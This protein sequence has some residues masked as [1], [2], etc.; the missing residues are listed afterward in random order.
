MTATSSRRLA[1]ESTPAATAGRNTTVRARALVLAAA[2]VTGSGGLAFGLSVTQPPPMMDMAPESPVIQFGIPVVRLIDNT[3]GVAAGGLALLLLFLPRSRW[4]EEAV[5]ART[6]A[7]QA[8]V[9]VGLVWAAAALGALWSQAAE[10]SPNGLG[11]S[12]G[13]VIGYAVHIT[14]GQALLVSMAAA[15]CYSVTYLGPGTSGQHEKKTR[16]L[17]PVI[18][19]PLAAVGLV[20]VPLTGHASQGDAVALT[21]TAIG[22]HVVGAALWVGGLG[23]IF[24]LAGAQHELLAIVLPRFSTVAGIC[25]FTVAVS[26]VIVAVDHLTMTT[27]LTVSGL[28]GNLFGTGYG[29]LVIGKTLC[30]GA[31]ACTGG[32]IRQKLLPGIVRFQRTPLTAWA[33]TELT[34]MAVALGLATALARAPM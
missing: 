11:A 21:M 16:A 12:V 28:F 26:G 7:R 18:G 15:I 5:R 8:A 24:L 9:R 34:I 29:V 22:L 1:R 6:K 23:A 33:G 13:E 25:I 3:A 2:A 4:Y 14:S 31:L 32:Y 10:L 27:G 19:L 30:C 17:G 20:A